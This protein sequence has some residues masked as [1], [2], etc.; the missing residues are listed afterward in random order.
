MNFEQFLAKV[1]PTSHDS[2]TRH[3]T[4]PAKHRSFRFIEDTNPQ[5]KMVYCHYDVS[6]RVSVNVTAIS[7]PVFSHEI[8]QVANRICLPWGRPSPGERD[9]DALMYQVFGMRSPSART[10]VLKDSPGLIHVN[11]RLLVS[12]FQWVEKQRDYKVKINFYNTR[13]WDG[14]LEGFYQT[15]EDFQYMRGLCS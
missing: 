11:H 8:C 13:A 7:S 12:R 5:R 14:Y 3:Y 15:V 10:L 4:V 6:D 2:N 9:R 1:G